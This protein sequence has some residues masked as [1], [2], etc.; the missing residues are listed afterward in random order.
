MR[1]IQAGDMTERGGPTTQ[2]GIDYQNRIAALYLGDLLNLEDGTSARVV[3]VRVE[4]PEHV[5]DIVV[6]YADGRS[7]WVQAKLTISAGSHEWFEL[8]RNFHAQRSERDFSS[9]DR[10]CLVIGELTNLAKVLRECVARTTSSSEAEWRSRLTTES[11]KLVS[12][13]EALICGTSYPIFQNL[14]I[15]VLGDNQIDALSAERLPNS[16]LSPASLLSILQ[17]IAGQG[18]RRR[19]QFQA[20]NLRERL[21]SEHSVQLA[22]PKHWGLPAYLELVGK[23]SIA[24][25]GTA[26]GGSVT[27]AFHWPRALR[28]QNTHVDFEDEY[29]SDRHDENLAEFDLRHFPSPQLTQ[30]IV[31]AGPGFGK[32]ALLSALAAKVVCDASYVPA[33]ISLSALSD[34]GLDVLRYLNVPFNQEY[35]VAIDWTRLCESGSALIML[36]GLDEVPLAERTAV[37]Q[38]LE[39]FAR[40]FPAIPWMLT[41]RDL[42][43]LPAG[44]E[45]EKVELGP[46]TNEAMVSF[47]MAVQPALNGD[48]AQRM[49]NRVTAYPE[50]ERLVRI[51]LFLALLIA[52]WTPSDPVPRRRTELIESYLKTLFRPEE[53]KDTK[54]VGD[55]ELLREAMQGLAYKLLESGEIGTTE[56][57]LRKLLR[58]YASP[59]VSAE[60][61][62]DDAL[63]CGILKRPQAGRLS[64]PFPIVQE[65]LASQ[66]LVERY[67]SEISKRANQ[68]VQRPWAQAVQFALEKLADG[69]QIAEELLATEDDAFAT[70]TRILARCILNGMPCS[71]GLRAVVGEKLANMWHR[72][73]YWTARRV[74]QLIDDGWSTPPSQAVRKA[75]HHRNLGHLGAEEILA[76]LCDDNL[77]YTV[78]SSYLEH[79]RHFAHLGS[80]QQ[81]VNRIA[82][83]AFRLYLQVVRSGKYEGDTW[84]AAALISRLDPTSIPQ[85]DLRQATDDESLPTGIRLATI[86]LYADSPTPLFWSLARDALRQE[87]GSDHWAAITALRRMRSPEAHLETLLRDATLPEKSRHEMI[88]HLGDV[89]EDEERQVSFL[90]ALYDDTSLTFELRVRMVMRA[91]DLGHLPAFN[92][93]LDKFDELPSQHASRALYALSR[94][95]E[96]SIGDRIVAALKARDS[97][98]KE[99]VR[100]ARAFLLG[101]MYRF[102]KPLYDGGVLLP[103]PLH[104]SFAEFLTL[105]EEWWM[106]TKFEL[107]DE[108]AMTSMA[109]RNRLSGAGERLRKLSIQVILEHDTKGYN[110]PLNQGIRS[111]VDELVRQ[112]LFLDLATIIRLAENTDCNAEIGALAHIEAIGT[113]EALDYLLERSRRRDDNYS[114][115]F[116]GIEAISSRLGLKVIEGSTG[117]KLFVAGD[118]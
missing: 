69:T 99:K 67:S 96:R 34:S 35:A 117:L 25:P 68:A 13:I 70:T 7:R 17:T 28:S 54:R 1:L 103:A 57:N 44:F 32:S 95:P 29:T 64:F 113:R 84:M 52:T 33:I 49:I 87:S 10:L 40:R 53:H 115:T 73:S 2:A 75:L 62:F 43:V 58:S 94:Y 108:L 76:K 109:A 42:A 46:L 71:D 15:E 38:K 107:A 47:A 65:Y 16:N 66:E 36:D 48:D 63:R 37:T 19:Q 89:L 72:Q 60:M 51:P 59:T 30:C 50:L 114:T 41:V 4:A 102:K 12:G 88:D 11:L 6:R 86:G 83:K 97:T 61:L 93:L 92:A 106:T 22:P 14:D 116:R 20:A 39:R 24:V 98:P 3:A 82:T 45:A 78:L 104:P 8:W 101:T 110:N 5:D 18:G 31:H 9:G 100:F 111:A 23:S 21:R 90:S 74:G 26:I 85:Q 105:L 56:R 118:S 27:A 77:T 55:P 79:P 112:R 91:S 81:A 80:F